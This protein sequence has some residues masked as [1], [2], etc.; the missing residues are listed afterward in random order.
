MVEVVAVMSISSEEMTD[1]PAAD[2]MPAPA[3]VIAR[4][5]SPRIGLLRSLFFEATSGSADTEEALDIYVGPGARMVA[6]YV[7]G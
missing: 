1:C 6:A 7:S 5:G 4:S 2:V 3:L